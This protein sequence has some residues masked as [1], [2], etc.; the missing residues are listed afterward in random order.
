VDFGDIHNNG[1]NEINDERLDI[2]NF[3]GRIRWLQDNVFAV[4]NRNITNDVW[5]L[6][7][8]FLLKR[9][10][11]LFFSEGKFSR[12]KSIGCMVVS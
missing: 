1:K 6:Y 8:L 2:D 12:L 9:C 11:L 7:V 5:R 3:S 4:L 10:G